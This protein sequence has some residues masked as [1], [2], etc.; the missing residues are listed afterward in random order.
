MVT[1]ATFVAIAAVR[2]DHS[3]LTAQAFTS[4][5]LISLQTTPAL[6]LL[7]AIPAVMQCLSCFDRIQEFCSHISNNAVSQNLLP[8]SSE[9]TLN[10]HGE[11]IME[12]AL[13]PGKYVRDRQSPHIVSFNSQSFAWSKSGPAILISIDVQISAGRITAVMGPTGSGKSTLLETILGETIPLYGPDRTVRSFNTAA[14][15]C[16][17]PWL[18][19][20]T[21][22]ENILGQSAV[23]SVDEVWYGTV[24]WACGLEAD[25]SRLKGRD[26]T[27]VGSK[28]MSLSGGQKQRVVG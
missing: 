27:V 15:C 26:Q 18:I 23:E 3:I 8:Q 2:H 7:Q 17:T 10:E 25:I 14:Y 20:G 22:R 5:S 11:G 19:N 12:L 21:I 6:I 4:L 28:G 16:Q 1:F 24:L 9:C 13:L